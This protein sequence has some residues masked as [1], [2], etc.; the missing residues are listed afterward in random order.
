M[1]FWRKMIHDQGERPS[2]SRFFLLKISAVYAIIINKYCKVL[3]VFKEVR[4]MS[5]FMGSEKGSLTI[6]NSV[7]ANIAGMAATSCY[8]VV[9]MSVK[10]IKGGIVKLLKKESAS[11]GIDISIGESNEVSVVL[12]IIVE[13]GTNIPAIAD[14]VTKTV[15]YK[16]EESLGVEIGPVRVI[17]EGIRV[18]GKH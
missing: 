13:Y 16:L 5:I 7:V 6:V 2:V 8:G 17:V 3:C 12:Y 9:G 15:R 4:I 14:M 10:S 11:R 1:R 18:Q